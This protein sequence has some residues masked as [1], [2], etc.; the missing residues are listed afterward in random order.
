MIPKV[1]HYV[2]FSGDEKPEKIKACID[3][4][5]KVLPDYEIR[6]WSLK[7]VD[8][9]R[10]NN[11]YFDQALKNKKWSFATDYLRLWIL[12][13][14]GGIY[15]DTDVE[16]LKSFDPFLNDGFFTCY[17]RQK[18]LEAAVMGSEKGNKFAKEFLDLYSSRDFEEELSKGTPEIIPA[19]LADYLAKNYKYKPRNRHT[20]LEGLHI[21]PYKYFSP[22]NGY[23][24][25]IH[26]NKNTVCIHHF[27]NTWVDKR[28][29][30]L[31][32][33]VKLFCQY[34]TMNI[35]PYKAN[36]RLNKHLNS[37]VNS[38]RGKHGKRKI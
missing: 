2:W 12:Y 35:L 37:V 29:V 36:R 9:I 34:L 7:D 33:K 1:I 38:F 16:V 31:K 28:H 8:E 17:E 23:T 18:T 4:W 22:K 5:L 27:A 13:N 15:L 32:S 19:I 25:K 20:I 30:S 24:R 6:E 11:K 10:K 21:Y 26:T 3:T 14:V